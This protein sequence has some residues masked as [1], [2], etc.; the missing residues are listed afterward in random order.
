ME[1]TEP[2]PMCGRY[3]GDLKEKWEKRE[4]EISQI[5]L[6]LAGIHFADKSTKRQ[7][8]IF[9]AKYY[10]GRESLA[11]IADDFNISKITVKEHLDNA[12]DLLSDLI[13]SL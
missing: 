9:M 4:K 10:H 7:L 6:I 12:I 2:C 13:K 3:D 5:N 1:Y 11:Q 8:E